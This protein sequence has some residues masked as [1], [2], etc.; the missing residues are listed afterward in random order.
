[1]TVQSSMASAAL[2]NYHIPLNVVMIAQTSNWTMRQWITYWAI[3]ECIRRDFLGLMDWADQITRYSGANPL[4][5]SG[6]LSVIANNLL[7]NR[8]TLTTETSMEGS[9]ID[10]GMPLATITGFSQV[11]TITPDQMADPDVLNNLVG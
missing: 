4:Q 3:K 9:D 11:F 8:L 1:M 6:P 5:L 10:V 2:N 7:S